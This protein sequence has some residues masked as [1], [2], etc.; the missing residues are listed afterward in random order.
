[1]TFHVWTDA[2]P[3][4]ERLVTRDAASAA[5][6]YADFRVDDVEGETIYVETPD[7]SVRRYIV[8]GGRASAG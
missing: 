5:E 8:Q 4:R 1:M 3:E 7:G 6:R 2:A